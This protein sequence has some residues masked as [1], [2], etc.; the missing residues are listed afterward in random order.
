MSRSSPD[1]V[2]RIV[3]ALALAPAADL[4]GRRSAWIDDAQRIVFAHVP[5]TQR[6][7]VA[8]QIGHAR[9]G[10]RHG[11]L[12]MALLAN[13][14]LSTQA[15]AHWS[16]EPETLGWCLRRLLQLRSDEGQLIHEVGAFVAQAREA[17]REW[18][19]MGLLI[20]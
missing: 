11:A 8:G 4:L 18:R 17:R 20:E 19:R 1:V 15:R 2:E 3:Q 12:A 16:F 10:H 14:A 5:G 6:L 7:L 9:P 13:S